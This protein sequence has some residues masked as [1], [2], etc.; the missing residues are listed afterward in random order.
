MIKKKKDLKSTLIIIAIVVGVPIL[1]IVGIFLMIHPY[2]IAKPEETCGM[3]DGGT[4]VYDY[5]NYSVTEY[6]VGMTGERK[7]GFKIVLNGN[8]LYD[9]HPELN[10]SGKCDNNP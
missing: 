8:T 4:I 6:K 7:T 3:L 1:L 9:S 2:L 5:G 10:Y